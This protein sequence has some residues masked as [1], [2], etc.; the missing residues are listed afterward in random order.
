M[1]NRSVLIKV[2]VPRRTNWSSGCC[3][4]SPMSLFGAGRTSR[5]E[6]SQ[7]DSGRLDASAGAF[8]AFPAGP[9]G[10]TA[11]GWM[12]GFYS[13]ISMVREGFDGHTSESACC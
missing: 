8:P 2:M 6:I 13:I 10:G 3:A 7:L 12:A 11:D 9:A 5:A 1:N 4:V